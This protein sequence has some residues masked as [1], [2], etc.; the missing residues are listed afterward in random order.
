MRQGLSAPE[1]RVTGKARHHRVDPRMLLLLWPHAQREVLGVGPGLRREARV[2]LGDSPRSLVTL[3][4]D[5]LVDAIRLIFT[6]IPRGAAP[7]TVVARGGMRVCKG[8]PAYSFTAFEGMGEAR[9]WLAHLLEEHRAG[10][11]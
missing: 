2:V 10:R 3:E 8:R 7:G 11:A 5:V 1:E 9:M 6:G 4:Q